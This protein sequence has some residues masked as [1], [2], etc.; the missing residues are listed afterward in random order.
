MPVVAYFFSWLLPIKD[1][2]GKPNKEVKAIGQKARGN[3]KG[4]W[5][6]GVSWRE[7]KKIASGRRRQSQSFMQSFSSKPN[8]LSATTP[9][10]RRRRPSSKAT[11]SGPHNSSNSN[12][13]DKMKLPTA[14]ILLL[15][16]ASAVSGQK[17]SQ[18]LCNTHTHTYVCFWILCSFVLRHCPAC[19]P[20]NAIGEA[21]GHFRLGA[22]V[23]ECSAVEIALA[24][25]QSKIVHTIHFVCVL[26]PST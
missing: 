8:H 24:P 21:A 12:G 17:V 15:G 6:K 13:S 20:A 2:S 4:T 9:K 18:V 16:V 5:E 22:G 19:R 11:T 14:A 23:H 1:K 3:R 25:F 10:E 26:K 7:W